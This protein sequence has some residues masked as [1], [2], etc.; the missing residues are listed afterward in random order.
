MEK[1]TTLVLGA[2]LNSER[3][4]NMAIRLLLKKG[5]DVQAIGNREG[6]VLNTQIE[7]DTVIFDDI[8][9]VTLYLSP[10]NQQKYYDYI[11]SLKPKRIIFNPGTE[12]DELKNL[13]ESAG[14]GTEYACTLVLLNLNQY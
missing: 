11:I 1:V 5:F 10:T 14:I 7:T 9:T 12:N 6:K 13:A 3:Y 2:S 8:H 4:S